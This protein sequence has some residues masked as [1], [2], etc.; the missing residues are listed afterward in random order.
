V[1]VAKHG[2]TLIEVMLAVALFA[3]IATTA[4][5]PLMFTV[6]SL[7]NAQQQ[8]I[9]NVRQERAVKQIFSQVRAAVRE[10]TETAV[11]VERASGLSVSDDDRI[12]VFSLLPLK[13]VRPAA[14]FVYRVFKE[15]K[16][17][18]VAGGLYR[19]EFALPLDDYLLLPSAS[20][21]SPINIDME[22]L[23][24][25]EGKVIVPDA[26]GMRVY[27]WQDNEW[28]EDYSGQIPQALK[29]EIKREKGTS[30]YEEYFRQEK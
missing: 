5:A 23:K 27:V 13:Q 17:K 4:L 14:V 15:D 25:E 30:E 20:D 2:F 16:L 10:G 11:R 18:K 19:F 29:I 6:R 28:K 26:V 21:R 12:A 3:I 22:K 1:R 7:K 24:P 9:V 8:W